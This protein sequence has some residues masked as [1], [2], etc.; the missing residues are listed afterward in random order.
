M[1]W[2][3]HII[4]TMNDTLDA[5]VSCTSKH[6][7]YTFCLRYQRANPKLD[8]MDNLLFGISYQS[9]VAPSQ[10]DWLYD[11]IEEDKT[12]GKNEFF[13]KRQNTTFAV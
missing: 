7:V 6:E 8:I 2:F 12:S 4:V 10:R 5:L 9:R 3:N 1:Q 13:T 11:I